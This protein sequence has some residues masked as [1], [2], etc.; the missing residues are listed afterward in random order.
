MAVDV[1]ESTGR[2]PFFRIIIAFRRIFTEIKRI[3]I[4]TKHYFSP[5][6]VAAYQ[7]LGFQK[8]QEEQETDG[9]RFTPMILCVG[10]LA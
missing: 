4:K 10:K 5:H 1:P 3:L 8:A 9:I 7:R 2:W 6:A